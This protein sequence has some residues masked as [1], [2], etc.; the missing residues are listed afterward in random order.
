MPRTCACSLFSLSQK[1]NTAGRRQ[2]VQVPLGRQPLA[3][4]AM[5]PVLRLTLDEALRLGA[6]AVGTFPLVAALVSASSGRSMATVPLFGS[7]DRSVVLRHDLR[8]R[9]NMAGPE[10]AT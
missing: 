7:G 10:P 9:L 8:Y 5:P 3:H 4:A 6:S 2:R 1:G